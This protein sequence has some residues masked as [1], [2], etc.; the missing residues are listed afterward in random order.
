MTSAA[1]HVEADLTEV[2]VTAVSPNGRPILEWLAASH[3]EARFIEAGR[4]LAVPQRRDPTA[5]GDERERFRSPSPLDLLRHLVDGPRLTSQPNPWCHLAIGGLSYDLIDYF[6]DLPPGKPDPLA[7]PMMEWWVPDQLLVID[8]LRNQV[9][10]IACVWGGEGVGTRYHDASRAI[11][12]LLA[13]VEATP[14]AIPFTAPPRTMGPSDAPADLDDDAYAAV[15]ADLKAYHHSGDVYQIVPS[16]SFALPCPDPLGAYGRLRAMNPSPYLFYFRSPARV[17]FGASPETCLRIDGATRRVVIR[18]IAGTAPRGRTSDGRIDHDTDARLEAAL[19]ADAKE[20]AEHL[21]LVDLA[22]NDVARVSV[23]GTRRV[24]SLLTVERYS[25]VMHLVS[26][27]EGT[28]RPD[29]DAL[30]AYAATMNMGTLVG[31]P[32]VRAAA[33]LR[34]V[35]ASRRGFYGGAVGYLTHGGTLETAIVIRSAVVVD[36]TAHIRAG[37]GIVLDSDP[38][39]EALETARKARAVLAAIE[40]EQVAHV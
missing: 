31:A 5:I 6:E 21:M 27:V 3:P 12:R 4:A 20:M 33:I 36:G 37:A 35:E 30:E 28:L 39:S 34:E 24:S 38:R 18:P 2:R 15:V 7:Q 32:K 17:L 8:H 10:V 14:P 22:R 25:H 1:V 13:V 26:E 29:V 23:A 40:S 19:R 9:S 16:R 11:E